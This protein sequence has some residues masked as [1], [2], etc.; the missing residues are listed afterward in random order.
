[1]SNSRM[2]KGGAKEKTKGEMRYVEIAFSQ[3]GER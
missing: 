3:V 1:M 2:R